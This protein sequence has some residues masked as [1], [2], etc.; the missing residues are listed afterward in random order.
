M[1][2]EFYNAML[3]AAAKKSEPFLLTL[4]I[5][6][7]NLSFG[8]T[9]RWNAGGG[10]VIE[11]GDGSSTTAT[12]SNTTISHTYAAAGTYIVAVTGDMYRI[13]VASN[14]GA[15]TFCNGNWA[16]LGNITDGSSMFYNCTNMDIV[17][18]HLPT[19]LTLGQTMFYNCQSATLPLTSLPDGLT[20]CANMFQQ[21]EAAT[22]NIPRLPSG[23]TAVSY[24]FYRCRHMTADLDAW[25]AANPNGWPGITNVGNFAR[26][27]GS[28]NSPGTFTGSISAFQAKCPNVADWTTGQPFYGT[29]T[30]A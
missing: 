20:N 10:C 8:V 13:T 3:A 24:M 16:A 21:C 28:L 18:D 12:T 5:T 17:V 1:T 9:P 27:A 19:G 14:P 4:N 22:M 2:R 15:V 6:D 25:V 7:D 29:N 26:I 30:T 23:I 11:W